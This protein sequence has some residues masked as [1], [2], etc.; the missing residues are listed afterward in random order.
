ML[1]T[2]YW[3]LSR[4][5]ADVGVQF[6]FTPDWRK[7]GLCFHRDVAFSR[8]DFSLELIYCYHQNGSDFLKYLIISMIS[9][10]DECLYAPQ[11]H[12]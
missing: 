2:F 5:Y 10:E 7:L 8:P 12:I 6:M 1:A 11:S 3:S 9:L 4:E